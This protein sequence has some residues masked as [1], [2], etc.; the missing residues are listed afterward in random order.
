MH[1][2]RRTAKLQWW[3]TVPTKI[4][5]CLSPIWIRQSE[6]A[7][8]N[9]SVVHAYPVIFSLHVTKYTRLEYIRIEKSH[10]GKSQKS[11][12]ESHLLWFR[13]VNSKQSYRSVFP[14]ALS[15]TDIKIKLNDRFVYL[16]SKDFFE[17]SK[18]FQYTNVAYDFVEVDFA[19]HFS[20]QFLEDQPAVILLTIY[21]CFRTL[22][23]EK[24]RK[25]NTQA[26]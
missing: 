13:K 10:C 20:A 25:Q 17:T 9:Y 16:L 19:S 26:E 15:I 22:K 4:G 18:A 3:P 11:A 6:F 8:T 21:R 7:T 1:Q 2:L 23:W 14:Y 5:I 24:K 12:I